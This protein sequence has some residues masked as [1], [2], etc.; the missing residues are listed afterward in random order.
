[1]EVNTALDQVETHDFT[2]E[3]E[4]IVSTD[5]AGAGIP[6]LQGYSP[7]KRF[8]PESYPLPWIPTGNSP[9]RKGP[10]PLLS[11]RGFEK[12]IYQGPP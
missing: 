4:D 5:A 6:R 3:C 7:S 1:M 8:V 9:W 12:G 10:R 11:G 2:V